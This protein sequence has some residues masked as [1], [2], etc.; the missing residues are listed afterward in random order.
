MS[1]DEIGSPDRLVEVEGIHNPF[2]CDQSHAVEIPATQIFHDPRIDW[3]GRRRVPAGPETEERIPLDIKNSDGSI[4]SATDLW[5]E[6]FPAAKGPSTEHIQIEV[7]PI[8]PVLRMPGLN[9]PQPEI[10]EEDEELANDV[11]A[12]L[13]EEAPIRQ[14]GITSLVPYYS[15]R[16]SD[17][18]F[19]DC[20]F[21]TQSSGGLIT[22]VMEEVEVRDESDKVL[23]LSQILLLPQ[24]MAPDPETKGERVDLPWDSPLR[25]TADVFLKDMQET[26][27]ERGKVY[28]NSCLKA[29]KVLKA[30][31]PE[32]V[33][34]ETE[35]DFATM[36]VLG[37]MAHKMC[38]A[39]NPLAVRARLNE[40][41]RRE[42]LHIS[43]LGHEDSIHD[44]SVY[45]AIWEELFMRAR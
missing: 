15:E 32:G 1:M 41:V 31:I 38:R 19:T 40:D 45:T 8:C 42:H 11:E 10:T 13:E 37:I 5:R 21:R 9:E 28:G 33:I 3:E 43:E 14:E 36:A 25:P 6:D 24:S 44:L 30:M 22:E 7:E 18:S 34:V 20:G 17:G 39:L 26:Y 4:K 23:D 16:A 12:S 35:E 27:Q 29:G 2:R